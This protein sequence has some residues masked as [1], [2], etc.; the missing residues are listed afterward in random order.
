MV[1]E[2]ISDFPLFIFTVLSGIAAGGYVG[3]ALLPNANVEKGRPWLF[4]LVSLALVAVGGIAAFMHLGRPALAYHMLGNLASPLMLE[5]ASAVCLAVVSV[6]DIVVSC[7][8][9]KGARAVRIVGA[10]FGVALMAAMTYAYATS[11]GNAVWSA[12]PT[13]LLFVV[14]SL[15][16]GVSLWAA[17]TR[18]LRPLA[19]RVMAA[20]N[21]VFACVLAWQAVVFSDA[22]ADGVPCIVAGALL[23]VV[24][25]I[26]AC[27]LPKAKQKPQVIL[28]AAAVLSIAAV[29]VSRYGFYLASII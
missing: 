29:V 26:V 5:G 1:G 25:T 11:Y 9:S 13:Y 20:L 8:G 24:G 27:V 28:V 14:G 6:V 19:T 18:S 23:A 22:G 12:G 21:G 17:M 3:A 15:A 7:K 4:P 10:V 2:M 16:G